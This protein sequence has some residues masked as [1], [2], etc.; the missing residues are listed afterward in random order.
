MSNA[1]G[2]SHV[3]VTSGFKPIDTKSPSVLG[4]L[5]RSKRGLANTPTFVTNFEQLEANFG[6]LMSSSYGMYV[7]KFMME[8]YGV[9]QVYAS[10]ITATGD[11]KAKFT[12]ESGKLV[13]ELQS[14]GA[15]GNNF[16]LIFTKH[17]VVSDN[18]SVS[19][20]V[21]DSQG[22]N[23]YELYYAENLSGTTT[24][25][26]YF[27]KVILEECPWI[28]VD[29]TDTSTNDTLSILM[30]KDSTKTVQASGGVD[31]ASAPTVN[32]YI[33][34][35]SLKT[36]LYSLAPITSIRTLM[37]PDATIVVNG[38]GAVDQKALETAAIAFCDKLGYMNYIGDVPKG[39]TPQEAKTFIIDTCAFD[40][41][42]YA[43]YYNWIK[44]F[45]PISG[46]GKFIP[47]SAM[48]FGAWAFT[49]NGEEGVHKAPANVICRGVM[50]LERDTLT[51]GERSLLNEC[52]I[53]VLVK[54][55]TYKV[56]GARMRTNDPEWRYIHVRRTYQMHWTSIV[57][58]SWW[59]PF[60][61]KDQMMY[62]RI[63]R[64]VESYFRMH[65]RRFNPQGSLFNLKNPQEPPY[66]VVCDN[67]NQ[68]GKRGELIVDW[69][70][71]VVDTNE[72][73]K[74]R[75]SLWDGNSDTRRV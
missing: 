7:L 52:G 3:P 41:N 34:S 65:D 48:G 24:N 56:F 66:Y 57:D 36:G 17:P 42:N 11:T 14:A 30:G 73:V 64:I 39:K 62:G 13:F 75:T 15:D 40:S 5:I 46:M 29:G 1:P 9:N 26:R 10:R 71:C 74:F 37:I 28:K 70:I 51:E 23:G 43:V 59:M 60:T 21:T 25:P 54:L 68:S 32:D 58:S 16:A 35:E 44:V 38:E 20:V 47:P 6:G 49:D 45:D 27:V 61:V 55:D 19:L 8:Y 72:F 33:G 18:Y 53:N 69:G 67:S 12:I 50:S 4:V 22:K 31:S 2:V 63:K